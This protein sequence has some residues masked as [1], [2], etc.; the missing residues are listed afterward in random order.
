MNVNSFLTFTG[1]AITSEPEIART[2]KT[3]KC[4]TTGAVGVAVMSSQIAFIY[5]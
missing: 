5:I 1:K 4:V 3:S 2:S